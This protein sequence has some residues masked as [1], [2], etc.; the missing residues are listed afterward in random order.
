MR[1]SWR[2]CKKG[3]HQKQPLGVVPAEP[4]V[5]E[6]VDCFEPTVDVPQARE[7]HLFLTLGENRIRRGH[8]L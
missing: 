6:G 1:E 5:V 2:F 7:V 3:S 8:H 4:L